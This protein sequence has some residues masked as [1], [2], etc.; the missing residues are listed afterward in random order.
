M[1]PNVNPPFLLSSSAG[2]NPNG[3]EAAVDPNEKPDELELFCPNPEGWGAPKLSESV[4]FS[5]LLSA[6]PFVSMRVGLS[7]IAMS[8]SSFL[9]GGV[10]CREEAPPNEKGVL[11][12]AT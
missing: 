12:A 3:L 4:G 5:L 8:L 6:L 9:L 7:S 2:F 11:A 1:F 10:T